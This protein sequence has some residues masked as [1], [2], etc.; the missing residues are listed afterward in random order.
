MYHP[1]DLGTNDNVR[2]E[3]IELHNVSTVPVLLY[4]PAHPTN[5]WHLRDAVDFHF[6]AGTVLPPGSHLLV[7]SFDP[8]NNPSALAAFRSTY[9]VD[10]SVP[11]L[12][13]YR[14]KLANSSDEIELRK[15]GVPDTN[16]VPYILV[17]RVRYSDLLPWPTEADGTGF[18]LQRVNEAQFANDPANW[19]AAA[20]TP[21]PQAASLDADG[22]GMPDTWETDHGLDAYNPG[23]A[24]L[25]PD[26]DSLTNLQEYQAGT[27][28]RDPQS[29]LRFESIA[30]TANGT[31]AV[32]TFM[33]MANRTCTVEATDDLGGRLWQGMF[34]FDVAPTPRLI[35]LEV[36]LSPAL[37]FYRLRTPGRLSQQASLR[38]NSI[39]PLPNHEV[40]L[41]FGVPA[42]A[43]CTVEFT[44]QFPAGPWTAVTNFPAGPTHRLIE[45][46]A[47]ASG[48]G[49]F[50]RLRSP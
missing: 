47:P 6:P 5:V 12:G 33:V 37:R 13:P 21:G 4:D 38:I 19:T 18:S 32:L 36:P 10:L 15:P 2:D 46:T 7:V 24:A 49:G 35:R 1:P 31:S 48:P 42:N 16:D 50:Y 9:L 20:P 30:L 14:G 17:E 22:D 25:D 11:I 43:S 28:P 39:Q 34:D 41:A 29:V 3:F 45:M 27:D 26:L 40:A 23:D 44:A 8:T